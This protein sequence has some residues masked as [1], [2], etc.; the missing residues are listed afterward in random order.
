ML[1]EAVHMKMVTVVDICTVHGDGSMTQEELLPSLQIAN[2]LLADANLMINPTAELQEVEVRAQKK[3][4]L[5][6]KF[7]NSHLAINY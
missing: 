3:K 7:C 6:I 2:G 5:G 4:E 1:F